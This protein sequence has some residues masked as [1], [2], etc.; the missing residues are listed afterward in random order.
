M[1]WERRTIRAFASGSFKL[2][3][4]LVSQTLKSFSKSGAPGAALR[5]VF[6][7][8][9]TTKRAR[10]AQNMIVL[11]KGRVEAW[12]AGDFTVRLKAR[13][14]LENRLLARVA[15]RMPLGS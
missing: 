10:F 14:A 1:C 8:V 4:K 11:R 9:R 6:E 7:F 13:F 2:K 5:S 15:A 3:V 12:L